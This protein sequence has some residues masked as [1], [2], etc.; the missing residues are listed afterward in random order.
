MG[1]VEPPRPLQPA[2]LKVVGGRPCGLLCCM[3]KGPVAHAELS[4]R[5]CSQPLKVLQG[6]HCGLALNLVLSPKNTGACQALASH[7][8]AC[9][10]V[11][12]W[13]A[14]ALGFSGSGSTSHSLPPA[15][16]ARDGLRGVT[17]DF[18]VR[19]RFAG[20]VEGRERRQ[21]WLEQ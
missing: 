17:G 15:H 7:G 13:G 8:R 16:G 9:E 5:N 4:H 2:I 14:Q 12:G 18:P 20:A 1:S 11:Q 19:F 3:V 10:S 6:S 21:G